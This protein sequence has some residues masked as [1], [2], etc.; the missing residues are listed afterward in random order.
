MQFA[1]HFYA[2][3]GI[4]VVLSAASLGAGG[5][6]ASKSVPLPVVVTNPT[7]N[8]VNTKA[9]GTTQ[10][11][12]TVNVGNTVGVQQDFTN[13]VPVF[14]TVKAHYNDGEASSETAIYTVPAGKMLVM[15]AETVRGS[16]SDS[17]DYL[18]G[19]ELSINGPIRDIPIPISNFFSSTETDVS[20]SFNGT[21]Y[22]PENTTI[23][24]VASRA[25]AT[26]DVEFEFGMSGYLV[27]MPASS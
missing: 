2:I 7:S 14:A 1:R 11:A 12:G 18:L 21:Y 24:A 19:A 27:P 22:M 13:F 3:A 4:L 17:N 26:G 23:Y 15:Q 10:V 6:G 9:V 8:P 20:G 5:R 25:A 16:F